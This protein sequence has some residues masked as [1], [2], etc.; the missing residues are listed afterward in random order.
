MLMNSNHR[1]YNNDSGL[2][3]KFCGMSQYQGGVKYPSYYYDTATFVNDNNENLI[4]IYS[5][6]EAEMR[7]DADDKALREKDVRNTMRELEIKED[8]SKGKGDNRINEQEKRP[9]A[10]ENEVG[11]TNY[12][13]LMTE[14]SINPP[15]LS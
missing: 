13:N 11:F 10:I 3:Y 4:G 5:P 6:K 1:G 15:K 2:L 7:E 8:P 12:S 14:R 9:V